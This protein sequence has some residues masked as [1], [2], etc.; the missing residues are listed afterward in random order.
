MTEE[1]SVHLA[2]SVGLNKACVDCAVVAVGPMD[3]LRI[4][5]KPDG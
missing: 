1:H 3:R 5:Q 4:K 2:K